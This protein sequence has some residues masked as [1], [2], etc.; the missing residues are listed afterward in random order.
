MDAIVGHE[1]DEATR[2]S[3]FSGSEKYQNKFDSQASCSQETHEH[4][5]TV[6]FGM[7]VIDEIQLPSRSPLKDVAGG[8]GAYATLGSRLFHPGAQS[9]RVGCLVLAGKDFP[10]AVRQQLIACNMNLVYKTSEDKLSTRGLLE[11]A[12][13]AFG[14]KTFKYTTPPLKA[15]PSDLINTS[16]LSSKSF[17]LLATPAEIL[18]QIPDL[19]RLR[20]Q[21]GIQEPPLIVWEPLPASCTAANLASFTQACAF[22]NVFS[23]NHIEV[24]AL[25]GNTQPTHFQ[26]PKLE[27]YATDLCKSTGA[28]GTSIVI[29]RAGEYGSLIVQNG[30]EMVWLPPYYLHG[31]RG[32]VDPTGAGNAF[33]GGF[34]AGWNASCDAVEASMYAVIAASFAIEQVGL[35]RRTEDGEGEEEM[36]NGVSVRTRMEE[37]KARFEID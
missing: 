16:L 31:S 36:W 12:D 3:H 4:V 27:D 23:P 28:R 1:K 5:D 25:Y 15:S 11:Y 20:A 18:Q 19:H 17:H 13:D 35:P 26:R 32:V 7:V 33:L 34:M 6:S 2:K 30:G 37:Y 8:S 24:S 9:Y 29:I 22:V 14:A 10:E 21:M